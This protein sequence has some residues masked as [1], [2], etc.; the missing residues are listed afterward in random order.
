MSDPLYVHFTWYHCAVNDS[1]IDLAIGTDS[2]DDRTKCFQQNGEHVRRAKS[3][4][5]C[6]CKHKP[7]PE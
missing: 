6:K 4:L 1:G 2:K 5:S 3:V 7:T